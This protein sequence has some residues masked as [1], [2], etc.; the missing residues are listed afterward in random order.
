MQDLTG[1]RCQQRGQ[2]SPI[3]AGEPHPVSAE[4]PFKDGDLVAQRENLDVLVSIPI[5]NSRSAA[6]A[7][8]TVR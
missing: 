2:E 8:V 4:L 1:Q 6:K 5:G 7:F 3:L